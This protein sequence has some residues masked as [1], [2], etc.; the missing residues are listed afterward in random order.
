VVIFTV[1]CAA[2]RQANAAPTMIVD[3]AMSTVEL[4]GPPIM[5]RGR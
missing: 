1:L 2:R 5:P 4:S 3:E